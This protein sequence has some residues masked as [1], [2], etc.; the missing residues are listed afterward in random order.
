MTVRQQC[1]EKSLI[2]MIYFS[3]F[4]IHTKIYCMLDLSPPKYVSG[5]FESI[6]DFKLFKTGINHLQSS[7]HTLENNLQPLHPAIF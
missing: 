5:T 3:S 7:S 4:I 2:Q 6:F 1:R